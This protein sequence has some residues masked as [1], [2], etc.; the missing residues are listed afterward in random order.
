M[1][2]KAVRLLNA[3]AIEDFQENRG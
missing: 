2:K 1:V 3:L